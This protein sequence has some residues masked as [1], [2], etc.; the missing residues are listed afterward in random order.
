MKNILIA[1]VGTTPQIISETV[2]FLSV[3]KKIKLDEIHVLTT[4]KGEKTIHESLLGK[5]ILF[6]LY[7]DYELDVSHQPALQIECLKDRKGNILQ[8]VRSASDNM[9]AARHIIDFVRE[10]SY[11]SDSILHCSLAGGR[12]TMSSYMALAM[13]LFGRKNDDLTHVLVSPAEL[14]YDREF[15]YPKPGDKKL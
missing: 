13:N 6:N 2:Y 4:G 15:Y 8:D 9:D 11:A 3:H 14:E 12:K 1:V 7:Q 10:K 5:N